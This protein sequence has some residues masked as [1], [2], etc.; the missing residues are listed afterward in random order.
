ME[1]LHEFTTQALCDAYMDSENY[2]EPFIAFVEATS[3]VN[4][5]KKILNAVNMFYDEETFMV[6]FDKNYAPTD[7]YQNMNNYRYFVDGQE[8]YIESVKYS[9]CLYN[10]NTGDYDWYENV[11]RENIPENYVT[12]SFNI[13]FDYT[14]Y[15][16]YLVDG[17]GELCMY[18]DV[19]GPSNLDELDPDVHAEISGTVQAM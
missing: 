18:G 10:E 7:I 2:K 11:E 4:Y 8:T 16:D 13:S 14:V 9:Y 5:N 12:V 6:S 1:Y 19:P 15:S 3:G 17:H